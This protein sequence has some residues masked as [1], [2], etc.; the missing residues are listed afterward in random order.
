MDIQTK[1]YSL[2]VIVGTLC[3]VFPVLPGPAIF[4]AFLWIAVVCGGGA[5]I[6]TMWSK[7]EK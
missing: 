6:S 5:A 2:G 1:Q 3:G 7:A 4:L